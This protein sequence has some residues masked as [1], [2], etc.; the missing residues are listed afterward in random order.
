M[1][2]PIEIVKFYYFEKLGWCGCGCPSVV[3]ETI[4]KYLESVELPYEQ[5][6]AKMKEYFPPN[7]EENELVMC[8][9]YTLDKAG[10][11]D[12][13]TSIFSCRLTDDGKRFLRA[14]KE[15]QKQNALD[16]F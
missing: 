14:I 8:L 16:D 12:H 6:D 7:G 11:T 3:L 5:R 4:A 9:A 2:D 10:F 1:Q 13:G 15:A